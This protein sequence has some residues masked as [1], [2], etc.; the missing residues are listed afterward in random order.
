MH[1]IQNFSKKFFFA[2]FYICFNRLRSADYEKLI[3]SFWESHPASEQSSFI[4]WKKE[5]NR[6]SRIFWK[7]MGLAKKWF[8]Q[9]LTLSVPLLSLWTKYLLDL[10]FHMDSLYYEY[11]HQNF[12]KIFKIIF[13]P[14]PYSLTGMTWKYFSYL[15]EGVRVW[16]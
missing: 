12:F 13:D 5:W 15:Y 10:I 6:K 14:F 3:F 11:F 8:L 9:S 16:F 1:A 2:V 4:S 7:T